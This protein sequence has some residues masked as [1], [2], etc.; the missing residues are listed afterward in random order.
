M[1]SVSPASASTHFRAVLLRRLSAH[2]AQN[3]KIGDKSMCSESKKMGPAIMDAID[4]HA[5]TCKYRATKRPVSNS[6]RGA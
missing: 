2:A 3:R 5:N 1:P 4:N 6:V